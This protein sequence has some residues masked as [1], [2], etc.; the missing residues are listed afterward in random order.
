MRRSNRRNRTDARKLATH[1][2]N[3]RLPTAARLLQSHMLV[4]GMSWGHN[5]DAAN[6]ATGVLH[7]A[8]LLICAADD[9]IC[10]SSES[11]SA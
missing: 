11:H 9:R 5:A 7:R 6:H 10:R 4:G 1:R 3:P 8:S 2:S